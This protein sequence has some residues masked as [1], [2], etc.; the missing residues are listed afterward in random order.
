MRNNNNNIVFVIDK[1][2][3]EN[4]CNYIC[5]HNILRHNILL[6]RIFVSVFHFLCIF[7]ILILLF[8]TILI[9]NIEYFAFIFYSDML[10]CF[11]PIISALL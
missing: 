5:S 2:A 11:G 3:S 1:T 8:L 4:N 7:S 6:Y 10:L 9:D